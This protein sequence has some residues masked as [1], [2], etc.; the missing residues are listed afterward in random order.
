MPPPMK[1]IAP[2]GLFFL[3]FLRRGWAK[4]DAHVMIDVALRGLSYSYYG[5]VVY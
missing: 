4:A 1:H 2:R 5:V 3:F